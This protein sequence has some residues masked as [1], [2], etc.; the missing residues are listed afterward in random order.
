[1][2][3]KEIKSERNQLDN[4]EV[5]RAS[6]GNSTK[7][8]KLRLLTRA[9]KF[10][11]AAMKQFATQKR[12]VE[13]EQIKMWKENVMQKMTYELHIIWQTHKEKIDT[14]RQGFQIELEQVGRILEQLELRSKAL[15]NEVKALRL[16]G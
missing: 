14:Q 13:K 4:T 16:P 10:A 9:K 15:E 5:L 3:Q 12:Q 11:E 8:L 6:S 1:M 7:R 2:Y